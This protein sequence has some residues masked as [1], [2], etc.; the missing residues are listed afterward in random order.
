MAFSFEDYLSTTEK[1]TTTTKDSSSVGY[2]TLNDGESALVRI[3]Y[4]S[5]SEFMM[6]AYHQFD[7]T[8]NFMKVECLAAKKGGGSCP[9]CAKA[10]AGGTTVS[11]AKT[12]IFVPMLASYIDK[13]TGQ[14]KAAVPVVW[15]AQ[16]NSKC[17]W[18]KELAMKLSYFTDLRQHVFILKRTGTKLDT[19]Y[20]LDYVPM[21]DKAEFVPMDF[22]AFEGFR[23]D[24]HSY[25]VKSEEDIQTY[26]STGAFPQAAKS[27]TNTA[28]PI[29][30]EPTATPTPVSTSAPVTMP[31]PTPTSTPTPAV[32]PAPTAAAPQTFSPGVA[33]VPPAVQINTPPAGMQF[34]F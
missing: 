14:P 15:D 22:S 31:V 17:D 3:N 28:A 27:E 12:R 16:A 11:K 5:A 25:W 33:P 23:I 19:K 1:R 29:M 21:Y 8:Q 10:S 34:T 30:S 32:T 18:A 9:L 26:I 2:L 4:S 20:S 13:I 24:K 6:T 7:A